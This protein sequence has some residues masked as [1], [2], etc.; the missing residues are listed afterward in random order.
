MMTE[1]S[2][3]FLFFSFLHFLLFVMCVRQRTATNMLRGAKSPEPVHHGA[4]MGGDG[5]WMGWGLESGGKPSFDLGSLSRL[6]S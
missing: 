1:K 6:I 5:A 4:G 2:V 3:L